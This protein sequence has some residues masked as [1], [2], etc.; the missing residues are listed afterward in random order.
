MKQAAVRL[1]RFAIILLPV[2]LTTDDFKTIWSRSSRRT[3]KG[4]E[5]KVVDNFNH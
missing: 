1:L 5:M 3:N 2:W 4:R